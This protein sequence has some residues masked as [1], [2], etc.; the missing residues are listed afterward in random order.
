M[1]RSIYLFLCLLLFTVVGGA[2]LC[3][4]QV[5][6]AGWKKER[7]D[8][9]T[10]LQDF[11]TPP[12]GFGNVA[13]YWWLGDPLTQER[14]LWQLDRLSQMGT[15]MT[16]VQIN[17]AHSD[18]GGQLYG[19]TYPSE[20]ALF[21][22]EWWNLVEWYIQEAR[23]KGISVSLSDYTLGI[24]QGW[25]W[26]EAIASYPEI[27][28]SVLRCDTR[29]VK[30]GETVRLEP[31]Q[32]ALSVTTFDGQKQI[33]LTEKAKLSSPWTPDADGKLLI[34]RAVRMDPSIDPMHPKSGAAVIEMFF[35]P[36][37]D[38][39][40]GEGGRGLNFFFSD[41][42]DFRVSGRL[43]NEYFAQEFL[44]RKGYDVRPE[45]AAL[46]ADIGPRTVKVRLDYNDVLTA[47]S[48]EHYFKPIYEWHQQRGMTYG[49]DH[50]GR[51]YNLTE[52]G[53]YFRT[54][55]W[56]QGPGSDQPGLGR[57]IVKAKVASSIAHL[58]ERP[59][60]WLEGFYGSG[61]GTSSEDVTNATF[62]NFLMGYNLLSFHGL[63]YSTH[64]GWWEWAPP[65]NHW[66]MPYWKHFK[67]F[68]DATQ[69][70]S[71]LMTQGHH[72]CDVAVSYPVDA[73]EG[74]IDAGE[75]TGKS[76][77]M[78]ERLYRTGIDVDFINF[79]S[80]EK[81]VIQD[82][83][84][85][86]AGE[87]YR[88]LVLPHPRVMRHA[89]LEKAVAFAQAGGM[90]VTLGA[91]PE[92]SDRRGAGDPEVKR[93]AGLLPQQDRFADVN[94][95]V[96]AI[97]AA[98]TQDI[99]VKNATQPFYHHH[100]KLADCDLHALYQLPE[101]AE[102][103]VRCTGKAELLDAWTGE[104]KPLAVL[105]QNEQI[106]TRFRLNNAG[107]ELQL[108]LFS[109]G[110]AEIASQ[111]PQKPE[112]EK[113]IPM[114]GSWKSRILPTMDNTFGDF[115]IPATPG[116]M[117]GPEVSRF[118]FADS[119]TQPS[120]LQ[121][122]KP[123]F[124]DST[125]AVS[126]F[127]FGPKFR[128]LGP[129]PENLNENQL[130]TLETKLAAVSDYPFGNVDVAGKPYSWKDYSFSWR[131][132]VEGDP[133][134]QGY[135]GLKMNMYDEFIRLGQ[136]D[137]SG[138]LQTVRKPEQEGT[139]YY[140][141]SS[142]LAPTDREGVVLMHGLRPQ[143]IWVNGKSLDA[144]SISV[145]LR[146]G[147]NTILLR[148]DQ[149]GIGY[150]VMVS[151]DSPFAK[152]A[153][154]AD[155]AATPMRDSTSWIWAQPGEGVGTAWFRKTFEVR[156]ETRPQQAV[157]CITADD[158][159]TVW[160]N[161]KQLGSG[162]EW[163]KIQ[164]YD[165]T[166]QLLP[167]KNLIA[168]Q[169]VNGGG[170]RALIAELRMLE[171]DGRTTVAATDKTWCCSETLSQDWNQPGFDDS[172]WKEP[173][174]LSPFAGSLWATHPT[175]GPPVMSAMTSENGIE[176]ETTGPLAM[177]WF[178]VQTNALR[179]DV[180]PFDVYAGKTVNGY[181]RFYAPPGAVSFS[182]P[183]SNAEVH[184]NGQP[185]SA[186]VTGNHGAIFDIPAP[187]AEQLIA[188]CIPLNGGEYGGSAMT[189]PIRFQCGEGEIAP[190]DWSKMD[191][192]RTYS[193]GIR[194]E[195]MLTMEPQSWQDFRKVELDLGRVVSSAEVFVNGKSA[196]IKVAAPWRFD[197]KTLLQP[198]DNRIEIEVYNTLGNHYLTIP[199]RY[200]GR[201]E[202][203]LIGPVRL[204]VRSEE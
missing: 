151:P 180:F 18:K 171:Q 25:K 140:L 161:G 105:E 152:E 132:G 178:D 11:Q 156:E 29:E 23:K 179:P 66:R 50:G 137:T 153:S 87:S 149:P 130:H 173:A 9:A 28:G 36:F 93:L 187:G 64:G 56:N 5:S 52:F 120:G 82:G 159:Y 30:A 100:R 197:V 142:I 58:N 33:D 3:A 121:W 75:S 176:H 172:Q 164:S 191:S 37:E 116:E 27:V 84:L 49:C 53:D 192:L 83:R 46:F 189:T 177:R 113:T 78:V 165:L 76:F 39:N 19:L 45:L 112:T 81:A 183:A 107:T 144:S 190:G 122:T 41:E 185:C 14:L 150:F 128:Q 65:C 32:D 38:H 158:A 166:Q 111:E 145:P 35:Q 91:L 70:L 148:Y 67:P 47:L 154:S 147:A 4:Q 1:R 34:V 168:V 108:I 196:G 114:E 194:Y 103:T 26:D 202:S 20:P 60:V 21:S 57:D 181:Y 61:W 74:G 123:E 175:M 17:Y 8:Q 72:V 199:T 15:G 125:W 88:V 109:P 141:W 126:S 167:G 90:V 163:N 101:N 85:N 55:R 138:H 13:F 59:R 124:D 184:V 169:A 98:F 6:P 48:E 51:G 7:L 193:G 170:P 198:G 63:Y 204:H 44:Q 99:V 40:P 54:Q 24:S 201:I 200:L 146:K 69:R 143:S 134:H 71:Y 127:A 119:A 97:R 195:K 43:W 104:R 2:C 133:G 77:A 95:A 162:N 117:I 182:L 80:I 79:Q 203:G 136:Y 115:R 102:C 96:E 68:F 106:G 129:L 188:V 186:K 174:V 16:G 155:P 12:P 62:A 139:R 10:L 73:V 86:I 42:L 110:T 22:G 160:F 31:F 89:T 135:H 92:Y 94:T 131:Y 118:R 157:L